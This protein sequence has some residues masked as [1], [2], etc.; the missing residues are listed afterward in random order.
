MAARSITSSTSSSA[1]SF[2]EG[3]NVHPGPGVRERV[4]RRWNGRGQ[5]TPA[6]GWSRLLPPWRSKCKKVPPTRPATFCGGIGDYRV[7]ASAN[8]TALRVGDP[9]TLTLDI[10][11]GEGSG[12]LD[13]ISAPDLAA[14]SRIAADFEIVDKNPTGHK[15]G[16][17]KR[18]E[19]ALRPKRAGVG[20]PPLAVSIFNPDT[21]EFSEIA[22]EP[23]ALDVSDAGH[24]GASDLVGSL[25]GSGKEEI[26]PRAQGI[27]QN[28]TDPSELRDERVERRRLGRG[29][30][31][32][33]VLAWVPDGRGRLASPQIGRRGLAAKAARAGAGQGEA[34][35][36]SCSTRCRRIAGTPFAPFDRPWS[37]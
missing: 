18:F 6:V 2:R 8:P 17:V 32:L 23:I 25:P 5:V 14:N 28:V 37:G 34:G 9:L 22:T 15:D 3:G 13:L 33:V 20:I 10:E 4:V 12:S 26:K 24:V 31:R 21:E 30:S 16:D 11:R 7:A 27:F 35:R 36:G 29:H 1:S 19:Y